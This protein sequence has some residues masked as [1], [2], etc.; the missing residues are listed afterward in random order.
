MRLLLKLGLF[1]M[2]EE[3]D[4][5]EVF[6]YVQFA[7]KWAG[8]II[9]IALLHSYYG[10][11]WTPLS[12]ATLI[13]N[14]MSVG[15]IIVGRLYMKRLLDY[16]LQPGYEWLPSITLVTML[17][18]G[19]MS[20]LTNLIHLGVSW[21]P[22]VAIYLVLW[23]ATFIFYLVKSK[24]KTCLGG[25][26]TGLLT[27]V[28][29]AYSIGMFFWMAV[30]NCINRVPIYVLMLIRYLVCPLVSLILLVLPSKLEQEHCQLIIVGQLL[31]TMEL[32]LGIYLISR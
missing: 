4:K 13:L 12:I 15:E 23:V 6:F 32:G 7:L 25:C 9:G 1:G 29:F 21:P 19:L 5:G 10:Y 27:T 20:C 8:T 3:I 26:A 30:R 14:I 11:N 31:S 28:S 18:L 22:S 2:I 16:A 24:S 17:L